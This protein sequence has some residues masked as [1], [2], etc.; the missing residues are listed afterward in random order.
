MFGS[1][2]IYDEDDMSDYGGDFFDAEG[3]SGSSEAALKDVKGEPLWAG[4]GDVLTHWQQPG[5]GKKLRQGVSADE[6]AAG[7]TSAV[8]EPSAAILGAAAE[9]SDGAQSLGATHSLA[10][11]R[12]ER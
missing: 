7:G 8:D 2:G 9:C 4:G 12:K 10:G 1:D 6:H 3:G 5:P 11:K